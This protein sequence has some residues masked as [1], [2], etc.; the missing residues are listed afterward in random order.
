MEFAVPLRI[1]VSKNKHFQLNLN[2]YRNAH[3]RLLNSAKRNFT[4]LV[5]GL[6]LPKETYEKVSLHYQIYPATK[7]KFDGMN[8]VSIVDK[9]VCDALVKRGVL[10]DDNIEHVVG[11][12][13]EVMEV[14]RENPRAVIAIQPID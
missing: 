1:H 12:T 13:W 6:D 3:F 7:R 14:D 8:V 5:M 2:A 9:F 11:V 10:P 4:E